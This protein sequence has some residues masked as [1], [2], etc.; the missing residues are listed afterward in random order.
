MTEHH[1]YQPIDSVVAEA[2]E[3]LHKQYPKLGHHGL[4]EALEDAGLKLHPEELE[5]F[6]QAHH[7][8]AEK[9][10]RPYLR[11]GLPR[12]MA[13]S[14]GAVGTDSPRKRVRWRLW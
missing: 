9:P 4:L 10:W 7:I 11:L 6:M 12:W 1:N 8:R 2:I 5:R 13:F 3:R 14:G